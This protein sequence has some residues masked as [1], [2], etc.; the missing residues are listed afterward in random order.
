M[1]TFA[2]KSETFPIASPP[3][4]CVSMH[5][6]TNTS[7][8]LFYIVERMPIEKEFIYTAS[9]TSSNNNELPMLFGINSSALSTLSESSAQSAKANTPIYS[10]SHK[11]T[12]RGM[13]FKIVYGNSQTQLCNNNVNIFT[14]V[15]TCDTLRK[16][17][18]SVK[19][20]DNGDAGHTIDINGFRIDMS[21]KVSRDVY[22]LIVRTLMKCITE[23]DAVAASKKSF[24]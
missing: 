8:Q 22:L 2:L 10:F 7:W 16:G 15:T 20:F 14:Y 24:G 6:T 23:K 12:I 1:S 3:E 4:L 11:I 9:E 17:R 13:I 18:I 19:L 21:P 5:N